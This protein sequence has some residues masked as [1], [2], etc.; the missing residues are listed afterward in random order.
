MAFYLFL[1][2]FELLE[3]RHSRTNCWAI[4]SKT[5]PIRLVLRLLSQKNLAPLENSWHVSRDVFSLAKMIDF[6]LRQQKNHH[7]TQLL[8]SL[9]PAASTTFSGNR[10]LANHHDNSSLEK[11]Y[12]CDFP[13]D[14]DVDLHW[15]RPTKMRH[16]LKIAGLSY[17][18][19]Q[20][21][22]KYLQFK[23]RKHK[24]MTQTHG[25]FQCIR[26]AMLPL[27]SSLCSHSVACRPAWINRWR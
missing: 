12:S 5:L 1:F 15:T 9:L 14:L 25:E 2:C 8:H 24:K 21:E 11:S 19:S 10:M 22:C 6:T 13:C 3:L 7:C 18:D 4:L 27:H 20:G 17:T 23:L 26:I 16:R